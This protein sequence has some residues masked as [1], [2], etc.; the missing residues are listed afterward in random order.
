MSPIDQSP[1]PC[2]HPS[3][4]DLAGLAA[5]IAAAWLPLVVEPA[6]QRHVIVTFARTLREALARDAEGVSVV[7]NP[8]LVR[9]LARAVGALA[10]HNRLA[11]LLVD[12]RLFAR[13]TIGECADLL[14]SPRALLVR[15]WRS[16]R[17]AVFDA[18][19]KAMDSVDSAPAVPLRRPEG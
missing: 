13:L 3:M 11:A 1:D 12:L 10:I 18:A 5:E 19:R 17:R 15:V 16:A 6:L 14:Q 4:P 2:K 8:R 9:E 7:R